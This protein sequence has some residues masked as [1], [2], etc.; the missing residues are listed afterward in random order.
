MP[1][2][3]L[4]LTASLADAVIVLPEAAEI[5]PVIGPMLSVAPLAMGPATVQLM[6]FA[7]TEQPPGSEATLS[8]K[9]V[10][11]GNCAMRLVRRRGRDCGAERVGKC[12]S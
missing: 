3:A 7:A 11:T 8:T 6:M 2:G 9:P 4:P 10:G 12:G 5:C 1:P